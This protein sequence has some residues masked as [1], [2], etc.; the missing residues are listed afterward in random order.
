[1]FICVKATFDD[2][3]DYDEVKVND[4]VVTMVQG[5]YY[6]TSAK[7]A[8]TYTISVTAKAN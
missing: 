3:F 4:T 5:G 7:T 1:M 6:C 8:G 2:G